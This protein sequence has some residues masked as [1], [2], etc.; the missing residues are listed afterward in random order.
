MWTVHLTLVFFFSILSVDGALLTRVGNVPFH[1][2]V[3]WQLK[4]RNWQ[5]WHAVQNYLKIY[6]TSD[7]IHGYFICIYRCHSDAQL[8]YTTNIN[9]IKHKSS[10]ILFNKDLVDLHF[11][12]KS[13]KCLLQ[14]VSRDNL[15]SM[16]TRNYTLEKKFWL[17][18][19]RI[20][21]N[22][23]FASSISSIY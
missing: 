22:K 7:T 20:N 2:N 9:K 10:L 11:F 19:T 15:N 5:N 16:Q 8:S 18:L 3:A 14:S 6:L 4:A 17:Y 21:W 13:R 12:S 23:V 1:R